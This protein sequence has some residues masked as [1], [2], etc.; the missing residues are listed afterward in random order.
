MIG[1]QAKGSRLSTVA[2]A[3]VGSLLLHVSVVAAIVVLGPKTHSRPDGAP[4]VVVLSI[5]PEAAYKEGRSIT[6]GGDGADV[7]PP[8]PN[9][10]A[11]NK[12]NVAHY[13]A[14]DDRV[15]PASVEKRKP[16]EPPQVQPYG[17]EGTQNSHPAHAGSKTPD[18]AIS[19]NGMQEDGDDGY[20]AEY[21]S[22][23]RTI[24]EQN[25]FYP[26]VARK[27][28]YEGRVGLYFYILKDGTIA[29]LRVSS[30]CNHRVLNRAAIRIVE[31]AA[32]FPPVR[33]GK[34]RVMMEVEIVFRLR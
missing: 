19:P 18:R 16:R 9:R 34:D 10:K 11:R 5:V 20:M 8:G 25:I 33:I 27:R 7:G 4:D 26:M 22:M 3:W 30:P 28:G 1:P 21:K 29:G 24:I 23:V 13:R 15:A 31:R 32:P 6:N 17:M 12:G 14:Q 2:F